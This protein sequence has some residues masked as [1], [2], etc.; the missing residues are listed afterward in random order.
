MRTYGRDTYGAFVYDPKEDERYFVEPY[1]FRASDTAYLSR[2]GEWWLRFTYRLSCIN[3][4][5]HLGYWRH[6][7]DYCDECGWFASGGGL[8]CFCAIDEQECPDC[9]GCGAPYG[10][11][12]AGLCAN[13]GTR[14]AFAY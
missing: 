9:P 10:C 2:S 13:H 14:R 7:P 6:Y 11:P 5:L 4:W 12:P 1:P 3:W 8:D